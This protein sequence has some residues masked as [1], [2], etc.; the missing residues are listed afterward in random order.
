MMNL[1][2]GKAFQWGFLILALSL[3]LIPFL[4]LSLYAQPQFDDFSI[5]YTTHAHSYFEAQASWYL[6]WSGRYT[7][8]GLISIF[9]PIVYHNTHGFSVVA[10]C[11]QLAF[12]S[13]LYYAVRSFF[14]S[15]TNKLSVFT[16]FVCIALAY[17][18]QLPSPSEAFYWIPSTFSYQLGIILSLL[19]F[20]I[21]WKNIHGI[22]SK[23]MGLLVLLSAA[24]PGTNEISLVIFMVLLGVTVVLNLIYTRK[25]NRSLL[26]LLAIG[27][28]FSIFSIKAP[29]NAVRALE[30]KEN[31]HAHIED[32]GFAVNTS[33]SIIKEQVLNL[34]MRS[35]FLLISLL[36]AWLISTVDLKK[37]LKL[38]PIYIVGFAAIWVGLYFL[39]HIPY[40][41]KSGIIHMPGRIANITQIV[42]ILGFWG[43]LALFIKHLNIDVRNA[44]VFGGVIYLILTVH[45]LFQFILPNKIQSATRDL[46]SGNARNYAQKMQARFDLLE[47]SEGKHVAVE[48]IENIPNTIFIADITADSN[49]VRNKQVSLYFN[50]ASVKMDSTLVS[51]Y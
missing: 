43:I 40:I 34:F 36:F 7:A 24:L 15:Q 6:N 10:I 23:Q 29:G 42:F 8:F 26:V 47:K 5:W 45:L 50:L 28:V 51:G 9:D 49:A 44:Q 2:I 3:I 16:L 19:F 35:P 21:L 17:Y 12:L 22:S 33:V 27:I 46:F 37:S 38:K 32:I 13:S 25:I 14:P 4:G 39:I 41:Y 30:L 11:I 31:T 48:S 20:S 1:N 18:W